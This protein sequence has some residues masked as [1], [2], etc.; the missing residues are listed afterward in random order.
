[1]GWPESVAD[2]PTRSHE[3]VFLLS[4]SSRYYYDA[5]AIRERVR[6]GAS[7][8]RKMIEGQPRVGGKH[9]ELI[10]AWSAVSSGTN[11][12]RKRSVGGGF[13]RNRRSVWT[14]ATTPFHGAH[15]A[16]F[17]RQLIE[18]CILA[19]S[20][21]R[22]VVIDPFM[23]SGTTGQVATDLGRQFIGCELNPNYLGLQDLR[24]TTIGMPLD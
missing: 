7:D 2:R 22:D 14:V 9:K 15:Y 3:Y 11:I 20:R 4:K 10:D 8:I 18:P 16:V 21:P 23:G 17:P 6:S 24:R 1:M 19:G 13:W 12:G 5:A